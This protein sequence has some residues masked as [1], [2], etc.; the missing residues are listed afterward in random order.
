MPKNNRTS[1]RTSARKTSAAVPAV[2]LIEAPFENPNGFD[3]DEN[4]KPFSTSSDSEDG[5][6]ST[7]SDSDSD[8][9]SEGAVNE[10]GLGAG[11]EGPEE[12]YGA[13]LVGVPVSTTGKDSLGFGS[14]TEVSYLASAIA[15]GQYT[16]VQLKAAFFAGFSPDEKKTGDRKAKATSFSVFFSDVKR[17]IGTYFAS[18]SL[19]F[20]TDEVTG[21]LSFEAK[22]L[23]RVREAIGSGILAELRGKTKS[24]KAAI[25]KAAGLPY[26]G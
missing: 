17:P 9:D 23:D 11:V 13:A 8:S 24:G 1:A 14:K 5:I 26:E 16:K 4:G 15:S 20:V 2:K 7:P 12:N 3:Y 25:L 22:R 21:K 18:R 19:V 10:N 6:F